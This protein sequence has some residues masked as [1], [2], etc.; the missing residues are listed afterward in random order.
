MN[1]P[2]SNLFWRVHPASGLL[3]LI[4]LIGWPV[5][6]FAEPAPQA[7]ACPS[8]EEIHVELMARKEKYRQLKS[9]LEAFMGG[10]KVDEVPLASLFKIDLEDANAVA[11]RV[12]QL[13]K[14]ITNKDQDLF[15]SCAFSSD[16]LKTSANEIIT[17]QRNVAE[18]RVRF[19]SL[20]PEKMAAILHPQIEATAQ[21]DTVKQLQEEHSSALQVQKQAAKALAKLEQ[22]ELETE[23]GAQGDLVTARADLERVKT[24]L[25]ALQ[26]KWVADLESEATFYKGTTAQLAEISR[27][28]LQSEPSTTVAEE[29][30][31][32]VNIWRIL[33]DRTHHMMA[34]RQALALP[35]LPAYPEQILM[36]AGD[37]ADSQRYI[38]AYG[39]TQAFRQSLLER[40]TT[41]LQES[42]DLHYRVLLQSGE[43]RSQLLNQMLEQGDKSALALTPELLADVRREFAIVPYRWTATYYV[44]L[45]DIRTNLNQGWSGW[46]EAANNI[47]LLMVFLAIPWVLWLITKS[48]SQRL[49]RLRIK[50]IQQ[51][52]RH[53]WASYAALL[54]QKI[55]PYAVWLVMLVAVYAAQQL[56]MMTVFAELALLLPYLRY[57]IYY[58]LFRRAMQCDFMWINQQIGGSSQLGDLRREVDLAA[59]TLGIFALLIFSFLYAVESLIRRGL[60]Y[61][62][63][64]Q[65]MLAVGILIA[66]FFAYQWRKVIGNGLDKYIPG[67]FGEHLNA[68]CASHW[69]IVLAVPAFALLLILMLIKQLGNWGYHFE[70]TKRLAAALFRLRVETAIS[71]TSVRRFTPPPEQY[72]RFFSLSGTTNPEH[73][74]KPTTTGYGEIQS[75]L[76]KWLQD[77]NCV[78]SVAIVAH[79]GAGKSCL[80]DYLEKTSELTSI[81][82]VSVKHKLTGKSD[83]LDFFSN[84]LNIPREKINSTLVHEETENSK[85]ILLIDDAHNFFLSSQNGFNG[86]DTLLELISQ[87]SK[88]YFWCLTFNHHAWGYLNNVY[89][90]H[91][92][93][94]SVI[95]LAPWPE[96]AIKNLILSTHNRTGFKLSY[97]DILQAV[98]GQGDF[99]EVTS[100]ENRF[101][102]LL[103]QQS[104]GN[105]RLA[106]YLWLSSLRLVGDNALQVGLPD[107]LELSVLS[108]LPEDALFVFAS[109]ARHENLTL[110]EIIATT[111]LPEAVVRQVLASGIRLKLLDCNECQVYR[112]A[113]LLQYPLINYLEAKHCLYE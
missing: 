8:F 27:F 24:E 73:L 93:F 26:V 45:L 96:Q 28:L 66:M 71:K 31:K 74:L 106:V 13:K 105:P 82:Q 49:N 61:H 39:D 108:S 67:K 17:L 50:M 103:R 100:I 33:V 75:L 2:L 89:G 22:A 78:H 80:L 6:L 25:T 59:K 21:A 99:Q 94:G 11:A 51:S 15:I 44:R 76:A 41:R 36:A 47:G 5:P 63:V 101:F 23:T 55:Q 42:V 62:L 38:G 52:R 16:K 68:L 32:A 81:R 40:I 77:S 30:A 69:G 9:G 83:V 87:S 95:R 92:Y 37:N 43:I 90:R 102:V 48:L 109:I 97:N 29:Y 65:I 113:T 64:S 72:C 19:L 104:R 112:I 46:A 58:R 91:H 110:T 3:L 84:L 20:P 10:Q 86:Y 14:E 88:N 12:D 57:Y 85:T 56:L 4:T 35:E 111:Q 70:L 18:L 98:G 107:E 79:K 60:I 34:G 1:N 53:V 7:I 54:I